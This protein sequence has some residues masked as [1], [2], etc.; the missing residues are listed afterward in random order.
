MNLDELVELQPDQTLA[1]KNTMNKKTVGTTTYSVSE[2]C[3]TYL[4]MVVEDKNEDR[5]KKF[6][7]GLVKL[8]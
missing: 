8:E 7:N 5:A 6:V 1:I 4:Q 3:Q 2:A